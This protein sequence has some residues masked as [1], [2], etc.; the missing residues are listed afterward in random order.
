LPPETDIEA[1]IRI[2]SWMIPAVA[3]LATSA[4]AVS[5]SSTQKMK[6][7]K[8]WIRRYVESIL[9]AV[10]PSRG[11]VCELLG[12]HPKPA[13]GDHLKSGQRIH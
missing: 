13:N 1:G 3:S 10:T 12:D 4:P 7:L 9:L 8:S 11:I 6:E 2:S 5:E